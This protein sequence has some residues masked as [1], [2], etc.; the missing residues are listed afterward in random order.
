LATR[1]QHVRSTTSDF[2]QSSR[3]KTDSITLLARSPIVALSLARAL[4]FFPFTAGSRTRLSNTISWR[5]QLGT[6]K[7]AQRKALSRAAAA[8]MRS[9]SI[10]RP[11]SHLLKAPRHSSSTS[12]SARLLARAGQ[13]PCRTTSMH[14]RQLACRS[15]ASTIKSWLWKAGAAAA[16]RSSPSARA[17]I[18]QHR[19]EWWKVVFYS[20]ICHVI[21]N[22]LSV[23]CR[24]LA[25]EAL[26]FCHIY[27]VYTIFLIVCSN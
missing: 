23:L 18:A 27:H 21:V 19:L 14:R 2:P 25:L 13:S 24:P 20:Y 26:M 4:P 11:T 15:A 6:R 10:S 9:G 12:P 8:P 7:W 1:R 5:N 3:S 17:A 16:T 22:T